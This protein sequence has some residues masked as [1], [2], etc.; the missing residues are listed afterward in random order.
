MF[1]DMEEGNS[2][3]KGC[4]TEMEEGSFENSGV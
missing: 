1:G 2:R 3:K 4:K